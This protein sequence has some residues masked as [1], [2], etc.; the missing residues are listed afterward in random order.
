MKKLTAVLIICL[1][2]VAF[3][4][5]TEPTIT[6]KLVSTYPVYVTP[7]LELAGDFKLVTEV[8][9]V[10][11][12]VTVDE[13]TGS[14]KTEN[15]LAKYVD[16]QTVDIVTTIT[17]TQAIQSQTFDRAVLQTELDHMVDRIEAAQKVM[18]EALARKAELILILGVFE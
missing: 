11:D 10:K 1:C 12:K 8:V 14:T 3:A 7:F 2:S 17:T 18:D 4:T 16:A 5:W 9:L 13:R 6:T 15:K